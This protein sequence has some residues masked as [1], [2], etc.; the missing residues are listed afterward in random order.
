MPPQGMVYE[1][2]IEEYILG[3]LPVSQQVHL[4]DALRQNADLL[5]EYKWQ[6]D[7]IRC[8]RFYRKRQLKHRIEAVVW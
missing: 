3:R 4:E 1:D 5:F 2:L 7:I 6:A 8:I